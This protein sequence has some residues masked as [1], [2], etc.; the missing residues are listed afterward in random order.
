MLEKIFNDFGLTNYEIKVYLALVE[1]GE[2]TT[3]K[4]LN[5]A[6]INSGKIYQI[7]ESLKKKGFV[8]EVIKN[9]VKKYSS[10]EPNEILE[11]FKE[12]KK[13]IEEKERVFKEIL[14]ELI[15]KINENKE[16]VQVEIFTGT[17]GMKKAFEKEIKLYQKNK[18]LR[19]NGILDYNK[20]SKKVV[21]FFKHN[22]FPKRERTKIEIRKIADN[23]AKDNIHEK[24]AKIRFLDYNSIITFNN[25]ENLTII[26]VWTKEPL[27][28]AIESEEMS[29]GFKENFELLWKLAKPFLNKKR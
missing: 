23:E 12:K 22:I 10:V 21:E 17:K 15:K 8:S 5:K 4:I 9:G 28:I 19:I 13:E 20:H 1:L 27:F 29:K 24:K 11:L 25:I 6:G 18:T 16:K 3:G 26:S 7:L 2:S 14:P